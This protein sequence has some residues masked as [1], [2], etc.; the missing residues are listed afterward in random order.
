MTVKSKLLVAR[1]YLTGK[2]DF[3]SP[4]GK[5]SKR[6]FLG[7]IIG[8][9]ISFIPLIVVLVVSDGM[10]S[11]ITTRFIE[12]STYHVEALDYYPE[13]ENHIIEAKK[14]LSTI[15]GVRA[16]YF[17]RTGLGIAIIGDERLGVN[18]RAVENEFLNE[19]EGAKKYLNLLQGSLDFKNSKDCILGEAL[20]KK[21]KASIGSS[22]TLVTAK[23]VSNGS[24]IPRLTRFTVTGIVSSGYQ[25]LDSLWFLIPFKTGKSILYTENSRQFLG[26]KMDSVYPLNEKAVSLIRNNLSDSFR[27]S[28]WDD[29][30]KSQFKS[31]QDTKVL[32]SFILALIVLIASVNI[33]SA[34][35]MM[36]LER[37]KDLA[38]LKSIGA[39]P[40]DINQ[41]FMLAGLGAGLLGVFLGIVMGLFCAININGILSALEAFLN[42]AGYA[43]MYISGIKIDAVK[44]L[45]P[46]FYLEQI[47]IVIDLGQLWSYALG[48]IVLCAFAAYLPAR[49]ASRSSPLEVFQKY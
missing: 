11:G 4:K 45:N 49:K 28:T 33:V 10:I 24:I 42:F 16:S 26:I 19:S 36:V 1:R 41:I 23:N 15:S 5:S 39:S 37:Q 12:L 9:A 17:E 44:L 34:T 22:I 2:I 3:S 38:I 29:L 43:F 46:E 21:L 7:A 27:I 30:Q 14:S 8:I 47:P 25:Q 20:A 13:D 6:F 18:V 35:V 48:T 31:L 32:L 40:R